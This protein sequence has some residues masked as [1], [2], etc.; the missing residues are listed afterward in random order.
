MTWVLIIVIGALSGGA[1]DSVPG[2]K[3]E[4]ACREAAV[5]AASQIA[6]RGGRAFCLQV[7]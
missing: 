4:A 3:T 5:V 2:F 7:K 6:N 1:I